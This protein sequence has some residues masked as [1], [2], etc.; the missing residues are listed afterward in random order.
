MVGGEATE[1]G[2]DKRWKKMEGETGRGKIRVSGYGRSQK[3][4]SVEFE[5]GGKNAPR[6]SAVGF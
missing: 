3:N 1:V 5:G 2:W 4:K 6:A